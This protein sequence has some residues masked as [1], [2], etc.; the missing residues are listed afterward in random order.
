MQSCL[1]IEWAREATNLHKV[2]SRGV[3]VSYI[4]LRKMFGSVK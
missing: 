1:I 4:L 3:I 2:N